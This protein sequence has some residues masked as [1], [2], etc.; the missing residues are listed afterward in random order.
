MRVRRVRRVVAV[1]TVGAVSKRAVLQV[2][3]DDGA[4]R[5]VRVVEV[6]APAATDEVEG[7]VRLAYGEVRLDLEGGDEGGDVFGEFGGDGADGRPVFGQ[8]V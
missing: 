4:T 1:P 3:L 2:A 8:F 6:P 5:P 7:P